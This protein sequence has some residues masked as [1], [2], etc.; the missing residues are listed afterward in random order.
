MSKSIELGKG[1]VKF[2]T[3]NYEVMLKCLYIGKFIK[4]EKFLEFLLKKTLGT[5]GMLGYIAASISA[6]S[7]AD[8]LL[9]TDKS[10]IS[11]IVQGYA[12]PFMH[13]KPLRGE[14]DIYFVVTA[15]RKFM[16][17]TM[18][19]SWEKVL[20]F[21]VPEKITPGLINSM[22]NAFKVNDVAK[23]MMLALANEFINKD[24][25]TVAKIL[26]PTKVQSKPA[27]VPKKSPWSEVI[28]GEESKTKEKPKK[29]SK[30]LKP[31]EEPKPK[32]EESKESKPKEEPKTKKAKVNDEAPK[33]LSLVD[34]DKIIMTKKELENMMK[35][36]LESMM[37]KYSAAEEA[38]KAR[39]E[40]ALK[41]VKSAGDINTICDKFNELKSK[42]NEFESMIGNYIKEQKNKTNFS[43]PPIGGK[44]LSTFVAPD[45]V[46]CIVKEAPNGNGMILV[47]QIDLNAQP[48]QYQGCALVNDGGDYY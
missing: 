44:I 22:C 42:T 47:P 43:A 17:N 40:E 39:E 12:Y 8:R 23:K 31:K 1:Y 37:K 21:D 7:N 26:K 18:E 9:K 20:K 13:N 6:K 30:V 5:E 16:E 15:S 35:D 3:V 10:Y 11:S 32:I 48:S 28:D 29:E 14:P 2:D 27:E 36:K 46:T 25:P 4:N 34:N 45:G 24:K 33:S 19:I 38:L 41:L